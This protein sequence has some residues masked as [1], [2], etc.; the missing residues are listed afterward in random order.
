[1]NTNTTPPNNEKSG[2]NRYGVRRIIQ[3]FSGVLIIGFILFL[4]AGRINW[5]PAWI[6]LGIYLLLLLYNSRKSEKL[7]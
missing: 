6:Y 7:G 3:V 1:M 5:W 4:S 2:L